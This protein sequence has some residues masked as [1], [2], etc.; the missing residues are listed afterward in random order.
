MMRE[1]SEF[2][3]VLF[4]F[5]IFLGFLVFSIGIGYALDVACEETGS[6]VKAVAGV[7]GVLLILLLLIVT[8]ANRPMQM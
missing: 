4:L 3:M 5:S 1:G 6:R 8:G 2:V 7:F